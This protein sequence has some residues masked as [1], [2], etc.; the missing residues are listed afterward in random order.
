MGEG[1]YPRLI[2][3]HRLLIRGLQSFIHAKYE[4]KS[5]PTWMGPREYGQSSRF[6]ET[7]VELVDTCNVGA[8]IIMDAHGEWLTNPYPAS[9]LPLP[10]EAIT[11]LR[12]YRLLDLNSSIDQT[13]CQITSSAVSTTATKRWTCSPMRLTTGG[14]WTGK[15]AVQRTTSLA[16]RRWSNQ[17]GRL[18][19]TNPT[20]SNS[21][22]GSR[23]MDSRPTSLRGTVGRGE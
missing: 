5:T 22:K 6:L 1:E 16:T 3:R 21:S 7:D 15:Q 13:V 4:G 8:G 2:F 14:P 18:S 23:W 17:V 9:G 19:S 11:L 10:V 20:V 12:T